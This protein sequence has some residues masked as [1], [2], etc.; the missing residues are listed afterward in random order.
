[1]NYR[2]INRII[3]VSSVTA[4]ERFD[5]E[6]KQGLRLGGH[7][8]QKFHNLLLQGLVK[9]FKGDIYVVSGPLPTKE[10]LIAEK[11]ETVNGIHYYH[12]STLKAPF[13]G[14]ILEY[15]HCKRYIKRLITDNCVVICNAMDEFL[16]YA[17]IDVAKKKN[18]PICGIVTDV[19][20]FTSGAAQGRRGLKGYV[21]KLLLKKSIASVKKFDAY[22]LLAEAMNNIVNP[23]AMPHIVIEGMSDSNMFDIANNISDKTTPLTMMYAGGIHKQY[24]IKLLVESFLCIN[25]IGWR[26]VVYGAGNYESELKELCKV[27]P[28]VDYRGLAPNEEVIM[29]QTKASLLLN[30][31]PTDEEFVKYSFPSK[32]MECMASGTPL[33]TTHLPSMPPEYFPYVYFFEDETFDGFKKTLSRIT[34]I[35]REELH[36]KGQLAKRFILDNKNNI[37]Q[38]Q[39]LI[40]F[41]ETFKYGLDK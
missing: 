7:Q 12:P 3:Y 1:M 23:K 16:T 34:M 17:A 35:N 26:L 9:V 11:N 28:N 21:L 4:Q 6:C 36:N 24:G 13:I 33:L 37:K 29:E 25:P 5:Q 39:K 10:K 38:A 30:P 31:R 27:N 19:P 41:L 40:E 18:T 14:Q 2:T 8:N 20:G 15:Y 32:T 22:M